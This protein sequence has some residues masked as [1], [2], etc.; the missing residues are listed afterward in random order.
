[1]LL[2]NKVLCCIDFSNEYAYTS[3]AVV[4]KLQGDKAGGLNGYLPAAVCWHHGM[5]SCSIWVYHVI[6]VRV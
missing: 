3:V 5:T 4:R 6:V 1:M 2:A